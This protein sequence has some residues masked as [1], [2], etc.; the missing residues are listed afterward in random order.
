[1]KE[2]AKK[3]LQLMNIPAIQAESDGEALCSELNIQN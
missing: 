1:M 2:E 3:M